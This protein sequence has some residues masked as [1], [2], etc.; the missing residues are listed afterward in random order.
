MKIGNNLRILSDYLLFAQLKC[1]LKDLVCATSV[2][3]KEW[4]CFRECRAIL[5]QL[6]QSF[7][8]FLT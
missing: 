8:N 3:F 1:G 4:Y 7:K 6:I 5:W 2:T